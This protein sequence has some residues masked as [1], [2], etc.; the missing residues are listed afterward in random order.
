M[1][2]GGQLIMARRRVT[3]VETKFAQLGQSTRL[4]GVLQ[5]SLALARAHVGY[6]ERRIAA[7]EGDVETSAAHRGLVDPSTSK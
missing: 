1:D 2:W 7:Y 6:I 4:V 3:D 5:Q